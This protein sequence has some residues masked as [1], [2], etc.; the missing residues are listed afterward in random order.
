MIHARVI[1]EKARAV[2]Q[3]QVAEAILRYVIEINEWNSP[4][5]E[6]AS[7]FEV[8]IPL[9][10]EALKAA[11]AAADLADTYVKNIQ[12][13]SNG[14]NNARRAEIAGVLVSANAELESAKAAADAAAAAFSAADAI[15]KSIYK[16]HKNATQSLP[17]MG[18]KRS[19]HTRRP[20]GKRTRKN[21]NCKRR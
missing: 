14:K 12:S 19:S 8:Q 16:A 6:K 1:T 18:G 13:I 9:A 11:R 15:A 2:G 17:R 20:G 5:A 7:C 10:N 3:K 4:I 21:R